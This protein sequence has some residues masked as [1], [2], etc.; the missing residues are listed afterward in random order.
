MD[1]VFSI[2]GPTA[3]GKTDVAL[4]LAAQADVDLISVD[5]AMVYRG[6]DIGTA[7]PDAETLKLF[8]HAL[9]DILDPVETFSV[10]EFLKAADHAVASALSRGRVPVLVGGTML[11]FR[12]FRDG[13]SP[14][15]SADA[16]ARELIELRAKKTG[17]PAMHAELQ[18]ID[19]TAAQGIHPN[20]PHRIQRALEVFYVT[21]IPISDWWKNCKGETVSQR[22][23]CNL[24]QFG[25]E[26]EREAI[27]SNI[28]VRFDDMIRDGLIDEVERL[29]EI[30]DLSID[31][32][33]IRSV[34]YRQVWQHLEGHFDLEAMR[35]NAIVATRQLA[36]RQVTWL[37]GWPELKRIR[38]PTDGALEAILK[39]LG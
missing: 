1:R 26:M 35:E 27:T 36:K 23:G 29:R 14:L 13:L 12:A 7:K 16:E 8:P 25:L 3:A 30:K 5:S 38:M 15:P 24:V 19:P 2:M 34:G 39:L 21:G 37:R 9:I 4:G 6:L 10:A 33:S 18:L 20:N 28:E 11:Y 22:L 17:W 32:P 31:H